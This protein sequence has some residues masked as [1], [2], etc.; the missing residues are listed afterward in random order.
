MRRAAL[1]EQQTEE[2]I[3]YHQRNTDPFSL[4]ATEKKRRSKLRKI[5][6]A[7]LCGLTAGATTAYIINA[8]IFMTSFWTALAT[9]ALAW[10]YLWSESRR[11]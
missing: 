8:P 5:A 3:P 2:Q 11:K 1:A 7:G 4:G 6:I 10:L 9:E